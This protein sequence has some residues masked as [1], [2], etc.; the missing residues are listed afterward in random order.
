MAMKA[1]RARDLD[2]GNDR[3][4]AFGA[5]VGE[6]AHLPH[7]L[8]LTELRDLQELLDHRSD[9]GLQYMMSRM[10]STMSLLG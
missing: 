7:A 1:S 4:V 9:P 6:D 10:S 3:P 2:F 8:A 5:D